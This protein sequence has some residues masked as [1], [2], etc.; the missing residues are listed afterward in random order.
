M[1]RDL[2]SL[3]NTRFDLVVVGAGVYGALAAWDAALRGWSVA[4]IDQADF[5]A[6]TSFNNH[7]TLHGGLRSLQSLD[8]RQMR[9]FI[10]E[11]RALARIAPHLVRPL[12]FVVPTYR[13]PLRS[14]ALMRVA[15]AISDLVARDR[16]DGVTDPELH[17]PPSR[18]ISRNECLQHNQVID[19]SGVTGG[20]LWHDYQMHHADRMTLSFVLSAAARGAVAANYVQATG[21]IREDDRVTGIRADDRLGRQSF[22]IRAHVVLNAA[23]PWAAG[24]LHSMGC[25]DSLPA[26]RLSLAMNLVTRR[27]VTTHACGGL[28]RGRFLFVVPWRDVSIVGTS[29]EV[30]DGP[31]EALAPTR[32]ALA[33]LLDDAAVAF[34]RAALT[35]ADVRLAHRGL[36]PMVSGSGTRVKL[37]RE[38]T[39]VD[40]GST[41][42]PRL[43]SVFG[44]RYTTARHTAERAIDAAFRIAGHSTPPLCR[45]S[46]TPVMGGDIDRRESFLRD[47]R[48]LEPGLVNDETLRRLALTYGTTHGDVLELVR[49]APA[50]GVPLGA[51]CDILGAEIVHAVRAESA[52]TLAD[53]VIRRTDAGS[54]GYPG[55]DAVARAAS[56]MAQALGWTPTR[57]A[58]EI[59]AVEAFYRLPD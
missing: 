32:G 6:G 31:A 46:V 26:A 10:R 58:D 30:Y 57:T 39:V 12:P 47:A 38:S 15:L 53:A 43:I 16:N 55:A 23:G 20:A 34:P 14:A 28:A 37:L 59:G 44:V 48:R 35:L 9:L 22:D 54:A 21:L 56:L 17:L 11:R 3:A 5:G 7:K 52:M 42:A 1:E 8:V 18:V 40:H 2:R 29:H 41:G 51:G 24:L 4:L 50:L 33:A 49:A 13:H 36:L 19:P 45:T 25:S 27:V